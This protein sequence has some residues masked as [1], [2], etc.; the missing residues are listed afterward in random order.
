VLSVFDHLSN[1]FRGVEERVEHY[2]L[3]HKSL[4]FEKVLQILWPF[5]PCGKS[6]FHHN[7]QEGRVPAG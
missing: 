4:I 6:P 7:P 2:A 1:A 3:P 5:V